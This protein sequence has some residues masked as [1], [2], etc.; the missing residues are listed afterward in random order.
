[1]FEDIVDPRMAAPCHDNDSSPLHSGDERKV[2]RHL[3]GYNA[4]FFIH[5][6]ERDANL[7]EIRRAQNFAGCLKTRHQL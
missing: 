5:R 3:I 6:T 1:V 4:P 7:F 2:V